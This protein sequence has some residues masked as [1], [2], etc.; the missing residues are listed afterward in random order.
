[1]SQDILTIIVTCEG[2]SGA[3]IVDTN[4]NKKTKVYG[5]LVAQDAF[6]ALWVV[7]MSD[8]L[9]DIREEL[10]A[11]TVALPTSRAVLNAIGAK[12]VKRDSNPR[13]LDEL[14]TADAKRRSLLITYS[15]DES[16]ETNWEH[17]MRERE[18]RRKVKARPFESD[19]N[20]LFVP[21]KWT[22]SVSHLQPAFVPISHP[23]G[24][25]SPRPS[26]GSYIPLK[27]VDKETFEPNSPEKKQVSLPRTE[28]TKQE[29][30]EVDRL[31]RMIREHVAPQRWPSNRRHSTLSQADTL[32]DSRPPS[33]PPS[34]LASGVNEPLMQRREQY[35]PYNDALR[36]LDGKGNDVSREEKRTRMLVADLAAQEKEEAIMQGE[37]IEE[38]DMRPRRTKGPEPPLTPPLKF[39][40]SSL[41]DEKSVS[42]APDI[43]RAPPMLYRDPYPSYSGSR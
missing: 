28:R 31:T 32:F 42:D 40:S 4:F 7:P 35:L 19:E 8:V 18:A 9:Q 2:S 15:V 12:T 20:P 5:L 30:V 43:H 1:M 11:A 39:V 27:E 10:N 34:E 13:E 6:E 37:R 33:L 21:S 3:W 22:G 26:Y 16:P 14:S 38:A 36:I 17:E 24:K 29:E 41:R 23:A 25:G